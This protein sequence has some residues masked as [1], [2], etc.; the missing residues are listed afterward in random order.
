MFL[1]NALR[2]Y[3][4]NLVVALSF[5]I[6][7]V[8]V[9]PFIL[10]GEAFGGIFANGGTVLLSYSFIKAFGLQLAL[11]AAAVVVFLFLYSVFVTLMVYAVRRDL[12][13]VPLTMYLS[14]RIRRFAI[15]Y[16]FFVLAFS[17]VASLAAATALLFGAMPAA[18]NAVIGIA[19]LPFLFLPQSII[20]DEEGFWNSV[21]GNF[22]FI[23]HYPDAFVFAVVLGFVLA[24][25]LPAIEFIFDYYFAIGRIAAILFALLFALPF[26]EAAKTELYMLK[27][28]LVRSS[29]TLPAPPK[30]IQVPVIKGRKP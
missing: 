15:K 27:Y 2:D 30:E 20:I 8:F 29:R 26:F 1:L 6:L 16:F 24:F 4:D 25:L 17:V 13:K 10:L 14:G 5:L 19:A 9:L 21:R 28:D 23:R 22:E 3:A 7:A 11:A 18:V 12:S